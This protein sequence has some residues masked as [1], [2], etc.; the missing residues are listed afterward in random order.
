[1]G[2]QEQETHLAVH[3]RPQTG[4][5]APQ[6]VSFRIPYAWNENAPKFTTDSQEDLMLFV[7]Q[8][9]QIFRLANMT[10]DKEKKK[11]LVLSR[12]RSCGGIFRAINPVHMKSS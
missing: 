6:A 7:E 1:M 11:Y 4:S 8:V 2:S 9:E 5:A 3:I 12:R 10:G